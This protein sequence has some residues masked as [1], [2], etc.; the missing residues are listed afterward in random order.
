MKILQSRSFERKVKKFSKQE[1]KT[2]DKQILKI[3]VNPS[4][5]A[6]KKA[7]SVEYTFIKSK[8]KTLH[9]YFPIALSELILN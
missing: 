8:L 7:T 2:L 3:A 9:I 4:V 5:G 6:E 1:K